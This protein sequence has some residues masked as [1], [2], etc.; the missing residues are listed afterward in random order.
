M[1][2]SVLPDGVDRVEVAI[3][4]YGIPPWPGARPSATVGVITHDRRSAWRR[5]HRRRAIPLPA[6]RYS[7]IE[8]CLD[9]D[10]MACGPATNSS[11]DPGGRAGAWGLAV[12]PVV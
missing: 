6:S 12:I 7:R 1:K 9:D 10:F 2:F 3:E 4:A 11:A 5:L 8:A